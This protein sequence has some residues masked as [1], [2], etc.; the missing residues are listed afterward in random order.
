ME[1]ST[2]TCKFKVNLVAVHRMMMILLTSFRAIFI[3]EFE[4]ILLMIIIVDW[5][6]SRLYVIRSTV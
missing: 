4:G 2:E 3:K 6:V 5:G 1:R